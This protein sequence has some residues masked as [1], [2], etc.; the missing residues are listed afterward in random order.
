MSFVIVM[1]GCDKTGK[2]TTAQALGEMLEWPVLKFGQ[3][4]P[5]G[6]FSEYLDALV[7]HDGPFIAD[8]FHMGESVY[9]PIYR[10]TPPMHDDQVSE[11][12][13]LLFA[14][15]ALVVLMEDEPQAVIARFKQHRE[16]FAREDDVYKIMNGYEDLFRACR[17]PKMR[18]TL[19]DTLPVVIANLVVQLTWRERA[20]A[21][22]R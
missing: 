9:G 19:N 5:E 13:E 10:G 4:G 8:R 2:T 3:P 14:R 12:E 22:A 16:D 17:L 21:S 6:A 11:I 18:A 1:E 7:K 20:E 15:G